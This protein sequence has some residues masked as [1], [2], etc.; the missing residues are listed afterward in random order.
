MPVLLAAANILGW[1]MI[2]PQLLKLYKSGNTEGLSA[3][4]M[5]VAMAMNLG[6]V[7][8]GAALRLW[9]IVPVSVIAFFLYALM[10]WRFC[11][12]NRGLSAA[13]LAAGFLVPLSLVFAALG[14]TDWKGVGLL[15][16][17]GYA[18]QFAPA[19]WSALSTSRPEGISLLTW[20]FALAEAVIWFL[21]G[22][23]RTDAALIIGGGGGMLMSAAI[24][25]RMVFFLAGV[26]RAESVGD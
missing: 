5:G 3:Q 16:G 12:I 15:L 25:L 20:C 17:F 13:H 26:K 22:M 8:Y 2:I 19:T 6:W 10:A 4:W 9:G 11:R 18:L 1:V 7:S 21:Y 14:F 24:V 23:D